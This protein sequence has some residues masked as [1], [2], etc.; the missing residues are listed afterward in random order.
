MAMEGAENTESPE[1]AM[2][3]SGTPSDNSSGEATP[4]D[5]DVPSTEPASLD[6]RNTSAAE[7]SA[8][9]PS[10]P[11][12]PLDNA[13]KANG[14][15]SKKEM[16]SEVS[17]PLPHAQRRITAPRMFTP[18]IGT[19]IQDIINAHNVP[20]HSFAKLPGRKAID[21]GAFYGFHNYVR[22]PKRELMLTNGEA[23]ESKPP[24]PTSKA[25]PRV[26][27]SP[28][29]IKSELSALMRE[30]HNTVF[31]EHKEHPAPAWNYRRIT[32]TCY[33]D[34][35]KSVPT[36]VELLQAHEI[37]AA[38]IP[39]MTVEQVANM[40]IQ[41]FGENQQ[42]LKETIEKEEIDGAALLLMNLDVFLKILR[43]PIGPAITIDGI[44]KRAREIRNIPYDD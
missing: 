23:P 24:T 30:I 36:C 19:S 14:V 1:S 22:P 17:H 12:P 10:Q 31:E 39:E 35:R 18:P 11:P 5:V 41:L 2:D 28:T 7:A 15:P 9:A 6:R 13:H 25:R 43:M 34:E 33:T 3:E 29:S 26:P 27:L 32:D 8:D 40:V 21:V 42:N 44:V 16:E 20:Q 37:D 38:L 4:M